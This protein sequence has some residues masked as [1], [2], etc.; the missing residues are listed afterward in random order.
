MTFLP[1]HFD[2]F[3]R[4][5]PLPNSDERFVSLAARVPLLQGSL[6]LPPSP[7]PPSLPPS[8]SL[9]L[10]LASAAKLWPALRL[11]GCTYALVSWLRVSPCTA[12]TH[13]HT[14]AV[15]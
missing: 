14:G 11:F 9:S 4:W 12:R 2:W 7:P 1:W 8:L 15:T 10:S 5:R 13:T 3:T 6:S